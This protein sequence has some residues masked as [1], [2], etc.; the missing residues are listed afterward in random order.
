MGLNKPLGNSQSQSH[1]GRVSVHADKIFKNFLMMFRRD[2]GPRI[3]HTYLHAVRARQ[4]EPASLFHR[5]HCSDTPFPEMWRGPQR[6]AASARCMFQGVVQQVRRRLLHFLII[7]PECR[8]GWVK[9]G[10]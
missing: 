10:V 1:S 8:D 4:T 9:A 6:Y 5:S 3:R 7:K 2:S